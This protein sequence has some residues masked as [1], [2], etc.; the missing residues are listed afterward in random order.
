MKILAAICYFT[1]VIIWSSTEERQPILGVFI[2]TLSPMEIYFT[3]PWRRRS[4]FVLTFT[5]SYYF[6]YDVS[7][8]VKLPTKNFLSWIWVSTDFLTR[9][10]TYRY[11][12][13]ISLFEGIDFT[14]AWYRN[15]LIKEWKLRELSSSFFAWPAGQQF[16]TYVVTYITWMDTFLAL[17]VLFDWTLTLKQLRK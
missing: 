17:H 3:I 9:N 13:C 16:Y 15:V 4:I 12:R 10:F 2:P 6:L 1:S 11:I 14:S 8:V 7:D 5:W